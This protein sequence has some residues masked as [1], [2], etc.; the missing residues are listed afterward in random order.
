M[1]NQLVNE[2][3]PYLL[4]HA[5]NPVNWYAWNDIA[6][7]L[8]KD[9]N[10]MLFISVGYSAC[11]WCHVMRRECFENL[12]VASILNEHFIS[13]KVDREERPD[14]DH[15]LQISFQIMNGRGGG[16]PLSIFMTPDKKPF[17]SGTYFPLKSR[18]GMLGF[19]DVL[20]AIFKAYTTKTTDIQ[21]Q[22]SKIENYLKNI[23]Q[24][25]G[26]SE[27]VRISSLE[28]IGS[29]TELYD[30]KF[31][32]FGF[33]PKFPNETALNLLMQE[34]AISNNSVGLSMVYKTFDNMLNGGIYDQIG[35]GIHRYSVDEKWLVPH[36]EKML[37][38]QSLLTFVLLDAYRISKNASYL[39]KVKEIL[40][41][42]NRELKSLEGGF[43][44]S[45][46]ADSEGVEGKY[47]V[48]EKDELNF[49]EQ[50]HI[51]IISDYYDISKRGNWEGKNILHITS[52][53]NELAKKYNKNI[54]ELTEII[55]NIRKKM[56]EKRMQRVKPKTDTKIITSWNALTVKAFII[57]YRSFP[58]ES[59][60]QIFI[61][62]A[63]EGLQHILNMIENGYLYRIFI[64]GQK[65]IIGFL[66]DYQYTISALLDFYEISLEEEYY[67]TAKSLFSFSLNHFYDTDHG[68]FFYSL[69]E[70][71]TII[72]RFKD[73]FDSPL[74]SANAFGIQNA[75]RLS[76]FDDNQSDSLYDIAKN[77]LQQVSFSPEM[78]FLSLSSMVYASFLFSEHF[79]E[80]TIVSRSFN[81]QLHNL[82]EAL[83]IPYRLQIDYDVSRTKNN[84]DQKEFLKGKSYHNDLYSVYMCKNYI[85]S[86]PLTDFD[87][88]IQ[89]LMS[90][91]PYMIIN[92]KH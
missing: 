57:A 44:S 45:Q 76:F 1:T 7:K 33:S 21:S 14:I 34:S 24:S 50:E 3:S 74:P 40:E 91:Y 65:S 10:K 73:F 38:N 62:S 27:I 84:L 54:Q 59:D 5:T 52:N 25:K 39:S 30:S 63:R 77:T 11:H 18:N 8:A 58:N 12:E 46:N 78:D 79:T 90:L 82:I 66:D 4:E 81:N 87:S 56:L 83:W 72:T 53:I 49:L 6:F 61:H 70:H 36:F 80:M 31:G 55:N 28:L 43:Y 23:N 92:D 68:G 51:D 26:K 71:Q 67:N 85:C 32:G 22:S 88:I 47:F 89:Y 42:V 15:L 37:Y 13:I 20:H 9:Q 69:N 75:L 48:W 35:G 60:K 64:D 17:Y 19:I 29:F 41:Y 86:R 2:Q 16:W